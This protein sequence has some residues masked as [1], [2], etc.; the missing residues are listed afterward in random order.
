MEGRRLFKEY[1][2]SLD[3]DLCFQNFDQELIEIDTQYNS[4]AGALTLIG[5]HGEFIGCAG[6]RRFQNKIAELKRMYIQPGYRGLGLGKILLEKSIALA[7]EIGY[8]RVRLDTMQ[9][10]VIASQ[11]YQKLGFY[12]IEAYRFNPSENVLYFE[13]KIQ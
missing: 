9:S 12:A 4:P 5:H 6:I 11:M 7:K 13:R 2:D 3:F 10:M 1:A 8:E